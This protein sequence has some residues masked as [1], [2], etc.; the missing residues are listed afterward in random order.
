MVSLTLLCKRLESQNRR[1]KALNDASLQKEIFKIDKGSVR[2]CKK[3][4]L[5]E[6]EEKKERRYN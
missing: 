6:V 1:C 3:V 4:A 2:E 5:L